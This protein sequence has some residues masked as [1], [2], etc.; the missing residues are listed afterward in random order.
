VV[1]AS[2][3]IAAAAL[4]VACA[5]LAVALRLRRPVAPPLAR[6]RPRERLRSGEV[7]AHEA[8]DTSRRIESLVGGAS[9]IAIPFVDLSPAVDQLRAGGDDD[10]ADRLDAVL[11]E[12]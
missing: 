12:R 9:G 10:E 1:V 7:T 6:T 8:D 3:V 2:L 4:A 11:R 5:S